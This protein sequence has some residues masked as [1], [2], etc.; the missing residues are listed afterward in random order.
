MIKILLRNIVRFVA[1]AILQIG[2]L[3]NIELNG[4]INPYLY[5]LFVLL[6]PFETPRWLTLVLA[7]ALGITIDVFCDTPGMHAT[8]TVAMAFI[9]PYMLSAI[10]PRDGYE[11]NTF[12]RVYYYGLGWFLKYSLLLIFI[13][14][15]IL[16]TVEV[17]RFSSYHM[18][19][20]RS[21]LSTVF[22]AFLAVLSQF[23][24]FRK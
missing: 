17:F 10:S 11:V 13:H 7:F 1:L 14:H 6:L 4:Y 19:I 5:V 23:V 3:N 15:T 24:V 18:V 22:T 12:P 9:R 2:V 20:W 21:V 8:A 16:F